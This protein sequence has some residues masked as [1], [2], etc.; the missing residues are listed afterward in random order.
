MASVP[1]GRRA[2]LALSVVAILAFAGTAAAA[3][4][5]T[6]V[7]VGSPPSPFSQNKQNE[8]AI[9]VNPANPMM[10]AAGSNDE[11]DLESCAAGDPT[12]CPF[13]TGVG[14]SGIYFSID[15]GTTW[16][17]PT[18][19]GWTAR[20]CLG[21]GACTPQVGPIGTLPNYYAAG[22][23]SDGDPMLAFGP[24]PDSTGAFAWG[25]GVRLYYGNLTSN[26]SSARSEAAFKGSEAVAVSYTVDLTKAMAG[27]NTGWSSPVI[28]T[29]QNAALFSDKDGLWVD[30]AASSPHFGAVYEC[31]VAFR[32]L[33]GAPEPVMFT[34]STDGGATWAKQMQLTAATDNNRTGGR[35]GCAIRTDSHGVIYVFWEGTDIKTRQSVQF[36]ARSFDGGVS[37]E[38]PRAVASVVDVGQF[39]PNTARF[40]FDGVAGARTDSFP[41]VDIA[42]GAPT[43]VGA[44]DEIVLGWADGTTP[45]D[46][47]GGP[48]E[49]A[50]VQW[51]TDGGDTWSAPLNAAPT[52]DRPNFPAFAIAP[53]GS[54]LYVTYDNFLQPWQ[55]DTSKPRSMQGVVRTAA[56]GTDG[57][58]GAWSDLYR[59]AIGDARGSSQN[60]LTAGFLGDYNAAMAMGDSVA[61]VWNDVRN[62]AD[63]PAIDTYRENL[64]TGTTPNPVPAVGTDCPASF[65]NT[66][67]Y[68]GVF[69]P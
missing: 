54:Q 68:G 20:G 56:V 45:T 44:T 38:K 57:T 66:D 55:S 31:N 5:A 37:F 7:T 35:Q 33:G 15:G 30:N 67:I 2:A 69:T 40:S 61:A 46:V 10:M 18:Y 42:N 65:G 58:P 1:R 22:L 11:I 59:G 25:N 50:L 34:R 12:T 60:G 6:L 62:A 41:S 47:S 43:G 27:D 39:D 32:S 23:V 36:M 29:K 63:C 13:T 3:G 21:P 52:A 9:A 28:V 48:N 64:V 53:D 51:S 14:V 19:T 8:P 4:S 16:T 24:A 26:F 17:Q 49:R